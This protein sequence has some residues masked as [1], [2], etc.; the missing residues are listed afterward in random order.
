MGKT[1]PRELKQRVIRVFI[2]STFI[3]MMKDRD[4]LV[5]RVFP[6]LRKL[7]SERRVVW[8]DVDLRWGITDEQKAEG[9]GA[10]GM[11]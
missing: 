2:S 1:P 5:A 3:D 11:P 8:S 10:A 4:E 7:C 6:A 9:K